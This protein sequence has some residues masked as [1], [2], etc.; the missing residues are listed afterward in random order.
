MVKRGYINGC[1]P[2]EERGNSKIEI[3]LKGRAT[4][5]LTKVSPE[6]VSMVMQH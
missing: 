5:V 6:E 3:A 4:M 1:N 2:R